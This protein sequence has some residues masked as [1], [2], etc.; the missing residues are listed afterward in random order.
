MMKK[1]IAFRWLFGIALGV[2]VAAGPARAELSNCSVKVDNFVFFA[3]QSGS[4][5]QRHAEAGEVKEIM[6]KRLLEQINEQIPHNPCP[7]CGLKGGLYLFAPFAT[8]R[9]VG[10]YYKESMAT[11]IGWIPDSQPVS[12]RLTP[13]G[14]GIA[15]LEGIVSP[16]SGKTAVILFSDGGQNTGSDPLEEAKRLEAAHPNVCVHVVSV[17]DDAAGQ[18]MNRQI[19]KAGHG[20]LYGEGADLLK[21]GAA[22][23]QFSRDVFCGAAPAK[24]RLVLRG[25]NFDFDK[26]TIRSDGKSVLDE[27][28]RSLKEESGVNVGVEGHTDSV[29]SDAYNQ[30]L[31]ERRANAVASY[32]AAGGVVR[33]RLSTVGFGESKPVAS[34]ETEDGRAQ[35]RRVE[36]R[37]Q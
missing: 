5:Y 20:C 17:A 27:A 9:D 10:E 15:D 3:D 30:R 11:R 29:G 1:T 12:L 36:F 2:A 24:R 21:N 23:E 28:V 33:R 7:S 31:S 37:I 22:L 18:E 35:N 32:L 6:V 19:A 4:M 16:L 14:D 8:L 26:S 25:V 13:M 34:N